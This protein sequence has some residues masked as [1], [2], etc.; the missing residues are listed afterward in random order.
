[1][2]ISSRDPRPCTCSRLM[3]LQAAKCPT[4]GAGVSVTADQSVVDCQHC[5]ASLL[6]SQSDIVERAGEPPTENLMRLAQAALDGGN[7]KE[8]AA[9]F[10]RVL[11][12][13]PDNVDAWLGKAEAAARRASLSNSRFDEISASVTQALSV[14]PRHSEDE[15]AKEGARIVLASAISLYD[16]AYHRFRSSAAEDDAWFDFIGHVLDVLV[17]LDLSHRLDPRNPRR[18]MREIAICWA[19]LSGHAYVDGTGAKRVRRPTPSTASHVQEI[20]S[21]RVTR[22]RELNPQYVAPEVVPITEDVPATGAKARKSHR[23]WIVVA[24]MV[25]IAVYATCR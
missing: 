3:A 14:A 11:E 13:E 15:V 6:M 18:I 9:Y 21:K 1:M 16:K 17:A 7:A 12:L 20:F 5:G 19:M 23:A 4:C 10:R 24:I 2:Q 25:V 8:A 22:M